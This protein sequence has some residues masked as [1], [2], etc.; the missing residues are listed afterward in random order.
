M[1]EGERR[2]GIRIVPM[3]Y[4]SHREWE[5]ERRECHHASGIIYCFR[6]VMKNICII[7]VNIHFL[8]SLEVG[9]GIF[10]H[11]TTLCHLFSAYAAVI[12]SLVYREDY[13]SIVSST[14]RKSRKYAR[15]NASPC[16]RSFTPIVSRILCIDN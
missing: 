9:V 10:L 15:N 7:Y 16:D 13:S 5:R 8:H 4:F 6:G 3:H 2:D 1:R 12:V 11:H 14:E